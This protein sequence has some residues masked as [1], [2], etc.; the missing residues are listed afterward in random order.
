MNEIL[1]KEKQSC[2]DGRK[3]V[4]RDSHSVRVITKGCI[5]CRIYD[6]KARAPKPLS[7][8]EEKD[9][10]GK[11]LI[12]YISISTSQGGEIKHKATNTHDSQPNASFFVSFLSNCRN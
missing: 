11:T 6:T 2:K 4:K 9:K 8:M 12:V 3:R 10:E 5:L 7:W 1:K